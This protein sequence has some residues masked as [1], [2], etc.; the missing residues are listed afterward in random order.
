MSP[1]P[2]LWYQAPTE[3]ARSPRPVKSAFNL[4]ARHNTYSDSTNLPH[5]FTPH[6]RERSI[7]ACTGEPRC[8][9]A[10]VILPKVYPRV[11]GGTMASRTVTTS[12]NGLSPRVRGNRTK[13]SGRRPGRGLSPRVR[14]NPS[15][16]RTRSRLARSIPACTGEPHLFDGVA[17]LTAR[18]GSG[19]SIPA[20]TGEPR[21]R[22][23]CTALPGVYPRVYG[24]THA[25]LELLSPSRGLSPRVRGN[26]Y[27]WKRA[28][29][30][31]R[32]IPACT[33]EPHRKHAVHHFDGVYPRVYGGTHDAEGHCGIREGLSPRVRG[34][35]AEACVPDTRLRSIPAC[36]GEPAI[37]RGQHHRRQVYPRVYG[38]TTCRHVHGKRPAG[39]SPRVRGNPS[40]EGVGVDLRRSIPA[41]TGEPRLA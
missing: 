4:D 41:C 23:A 3:E 25:T 21:P 11:Y 38:G 39:L 28:R 10:S 27:T 35:R 6:F 19:R 16:A 15:D 7:P 33:G 2:T 8:C 22:R 29:S 14:G 36:T 32:S 18:H 12:W 30:C 24:G 37:H 17:V 34:N 5:G 13:S 31:A 26:R 1:D 20:C 9:P 40:G